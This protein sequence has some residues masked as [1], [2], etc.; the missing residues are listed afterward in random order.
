MPYVKLRI[1]ARPVIYESHLLTSLLGAPSGRSDGMRSPRLLLLVKRSIYWSASV[2]VRFHGTVSVM[3]KTRYLVFIIPYLALPWSYV[4]A[5]RRSTYCSWM[6]SMKHNISTVVRV[7]RT[8]SN[9]VLLSRSSLMNALNLRNRPSWAWSPQEH[10][11][12]S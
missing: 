1:A 2:D 7:E 10:Q 3:E 5:H 11:E 9:D 4:C 12:L 6:V 8:R